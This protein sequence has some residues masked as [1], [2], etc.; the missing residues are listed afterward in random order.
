MVLLRCSE[1]SPS[2]ESGE[3]MPNRLV[4]TVSYPC[5]KP[6]METGPMAV[7]TQ[8]VATFLFMK[9]DDSDLNAPGPDT[10]PRP[11]CTGTA[12]AGT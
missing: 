6:T 7:L 10:V 5:G 8:G 1:L 4:C 3:G 11:V 12:G 2:L 9:V